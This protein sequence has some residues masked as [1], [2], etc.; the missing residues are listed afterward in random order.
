MVSTGNPSGIRKAGAGGRR[1]LLHTLAPK[2]CGFNDASIVTEL[3]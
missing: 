3:V 1:T 2:I